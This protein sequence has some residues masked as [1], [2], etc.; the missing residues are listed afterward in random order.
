MKWTLVF[1][2]L[3]LTLHTSF[4]FANDDLCNKKD[5]HVDH[6][7]RAGVIYNP[8]PV[9]VPDP[10]DIPITIDLADRYGLDV[11]AGIELDVP[12]GFISVY[13]DGRILHDGKNISGDIKD[14]CDEQQTGKDSDQ[15]NTGSELPGMV[16]RGDQGG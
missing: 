1:T 6:Q 15:S 2:A 4:G 12:L 14:K 5:Y 8:F 3:I 13:K 11:L 7:P 9:K 10:I 16:S